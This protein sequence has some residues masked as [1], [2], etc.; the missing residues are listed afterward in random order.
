MK[1]WIDDLRYPPEGWVWARSS[2][3]AVLHL[4]M[5]H[6]QVVSFDHD[7][8]GDDTGMKVMDWMI[9]YMDIDEWPRQIN[10]H[11][12]NPVGVRNLINRAR[13][14]SPPGTVIQQ[15]SV[16]DRVDRPDQD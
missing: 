5:R 13:D 4:T 3:E 9:E 11:S 6:W 7:L 14:Y 15:V 16:R 8:G 2:D 1:L 12:A 10:V